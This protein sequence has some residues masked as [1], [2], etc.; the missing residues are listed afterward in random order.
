MRDNVGRSIE[1]I[2]G[3]AAILK[4]MREFIRRGDSGRTF[5]RPADILS[6]RAALVRPLAAQDGY[7][8]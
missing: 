4:G 5:V 2:D 1:Q 7:A 3:G 6:E 8:F